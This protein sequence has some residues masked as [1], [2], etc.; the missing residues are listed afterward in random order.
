MTVSFTINGNPIQTIVYVTGEV[1]VLET[2][3]RGVDG[4]TRWTR[5]RY[6]GH[7]GPRWKPARH[8]R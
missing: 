2:D 4:K 1:P 3:V 7:A 5:V 8:S 6:S